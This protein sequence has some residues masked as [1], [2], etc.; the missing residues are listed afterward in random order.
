MSEGEKHYINSNHIFTK[1][2]AKESVKE[3]ESKIAEKGRGKDFILHG[4]IYLLCF[5]NLILFFF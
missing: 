5:S 4:L 2:E 1:T 3:A